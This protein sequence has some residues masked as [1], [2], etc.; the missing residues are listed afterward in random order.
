MQSDKEWGPVTD[1]AATV[2]AAESGLQPRRGLHYRRPA[3]RRASVS[4]GALWCLIYG[5]MTPTRNQ[6]SFTSKSLEAPCSRRDSAQPY[7]FRLRTLVVNSGESQHSA[8]NC[9][10]DRAALSSQYLVSIARLLGRS[11][12]RQH[13]IRVFRAPTGRDEYAYI[14]TEDYINMLQLLQSEHKVRLQRLVSRH[15][16]K[17]SEPNSPSQC[18]A[19]DSGSA[20]ELAQR[21][22]GLLGAKMTGGIRSE[23]L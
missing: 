5:V 13:V 4:T 17:K 2:H 20:D 12:R 3:A 19:Y 9:F 22:W 11:C 18:A 16:R 6:R 14:L 8:N 23:L 21:N 10:N 7:L 15:S 1:W